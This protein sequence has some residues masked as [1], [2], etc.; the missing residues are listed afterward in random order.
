MPNDTYVYFVVYKDLI[1][2]TERVEKGSVQVV[3]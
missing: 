2:N 3:R 1:T